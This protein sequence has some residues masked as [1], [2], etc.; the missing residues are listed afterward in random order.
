MNHLALARTVVGFGLVAVLLSLLPYRLPGEV[1]DG[2][3]RATEGA[4]C[5]T[6]PEAQ[7][8]AAVGLRVDRGRPWLTVRF[9]APPQDARV[10]VLVGESEVPVRLQQRPDGDWSMEVR[11]DSGLVLE[12]FMVG[13]R[14]DKVV[15]EL[16]ASASTG[17]VFGSPLTPIPESVRGPNVID[18]LIVVVVAIGAWR[19]YLSGARGMATQLMAVAVI[20]L[21]LKVVAPSLGEGASGMAIAFGYGVVVALVGIGVHELAQRGAARL[22]RGPAVEPGPRGLGALLGVVRAAVIAALLL[23]VLGDQALSDVVSA[24]VDRSSGGAW[25]VD[26][27]RALFE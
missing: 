16:P 12:R 3:L 7:Q 17:V 27:W 22:V 25:L 26:V 6:C 8:I 2:D 4:L 13:A 23:A 11:N 14:G 10:E 24:A 20:V 15:F 9:V 5:A 21:L 1:R 18:L 19:G